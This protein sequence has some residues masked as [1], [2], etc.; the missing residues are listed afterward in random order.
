[1]YDMGGISSASKALQQVLCPQTRMKGIAA[2]AFAGAAIVLAGC[3]TGQ[4][5]RPAA[6]VTVTVTASPHAPSAGT[7]S[8]ESATANERMIV[9]ALAASIAVIPARAVAGPLMG[10]YARFQNAYGAALGAVGQ[11]NSSGSV[12]PITGGFNLCYPA[13]AS[14]AASCEAFTQF[15]TN[16]AGQVTGMAV[17]GQPVAG[18]IATA[19]AATSD[20][21]K[22][23]GVVAYRLTGANVVVVAFKLT[24]SS[25]RP[26]NTSP[27]LLASLNGASDAVSQDALPAY[28]A[29]GDALYAAAGFDITQITGRF[30]L[31]PNDGFGE[32]LPCTTLSRV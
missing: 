10:A 9:E 29:P 17:K 26:R 4:T 31:E 3:G 23:S 13:T 5:P 19:P 14:S 28:L 6:T 24:D 2:L 25:Y 16:Q 11:P 12:T 7:S 8:P 15:S 22:I 27:S 18:R 21:L 1:M 32:Q 20:G 30:C